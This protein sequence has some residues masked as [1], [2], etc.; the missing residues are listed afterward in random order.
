MQSDQNNGNNRTDVLAAAASFPPSAAGWYAEEYEEGVN[1]RDYWYVLKKR[2]WWALGFTGG[3]VLVALLVVLFMPRIWEGKITLQITQDKGSSALGDA[4]SSMDPLGAL[5]GSSDLD[6]FYATQ[7]EI[8]KSP[9][10]AFGII[11]DLKLQSDPS[12]GEM[13]KEYPDYPPGAIRQLYAKQL[14]KH[15]SIEPVTNSYLVDIIFHSKDK[16]LAQKVPEALQ[17]V[18]LNLC[19]RTRQQ[20]FVLL[21]DWLDRQLVH[22]GEKLQVSEKKTIAAGEKGD[23]MGVDIDNDKM[24]A[25]NVVLQ[26][27]VQ[28]GQLLTTAQSDLAAKKALYDQIQQKGAD[29]P[30]IVNNPLIQTL[31]GQ[32]IAAEGQTS[33]SAQVYGPRFPSQKMGVATVNALTRKLNAEVR[34][35]AV[36]VRSDYQAALRAENLL[37]QEFAKAKAQMAGMEN[38]LAKFHMLKRDLATNQALYEGLLGRMKDAAVAATMVP[39]NIAVINASLPPYKPYM[40]KPALFLVLGLVLG[41]MVGIGLAFFLEYL[42]NSI[43]TVEELEKII[44]VPS[45]GMIPMAEKGE[46]GKTALETISYFEPKSQI[47]EAVSHIRSAI[48]LS[49]SSTPPQVIMITSG[50]PAEGKSTSTCNIAIALCRGEHK[51]VIIDCDLRKPRLHRVFKQSNRRGLSNFLTGGATLE[52]I[53]K[54]TEIPELYFIPAG[55]TPPSPLDLI[56]SEAFKKMIESLR[57]QYQHVVIDSPPV[58]GF[59]DARSLSAVSDGTVLVFRHLSTTR[60]A[61][62]LAVQMLTQINSQIL[63]SVLTMVRKSDLG[64]GAYYSYYKYYNKYYENYKEPDNKALKEM[65]SPKNGERPEG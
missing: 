25:M 7:Y 50:N 41:A 57:R 26:K 9:A 64:Y 14:L 40:P 22:L 6:R 53:T 47:S 39:S 43:K 46:A 44:H 59:A 45:L 18:Y 29:A 23:F 55:P 61:A 35:E 38:G 4:G 62:R 1:L 36:S 12:Y 51:C 24:A 17:G 65:P 5:T 3:V 56:A 49:A 54:A 52:E 28:V 8:L 2:K 16:G 60:E 13:A 30:V 34:R 31:R 42:D 58:I 32:L 11:D 37:Q 33:G 15:L 48:M 10:M 27:Y 21:K 19:M 63:G 20:S